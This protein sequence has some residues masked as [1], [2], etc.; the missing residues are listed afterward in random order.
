M[1]NRGAEPFRA[2]TLTRLPNLDTFTEKM[3]PDNVENVF[4]WS[5]NPKEDLAYKNIAELLNAKFQQMA[6]AI[7][8][9]CPDNDDRNDALK[10]LRSVHFKVAMS[11]N[12]R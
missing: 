3:H 4:K 8:V 11:L 2:R 12:S 6:R 7:L 10:I 5:I 1:S 9:N